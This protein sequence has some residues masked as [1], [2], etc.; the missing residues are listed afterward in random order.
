M[1]IKIEL[2]DSYFLSKF[3]VDDITEDYIDWL[4]DPKIVNFLEV[5]FL[6]QDRETVTSYINSF[7]KDFEKYL[8]GVYSKDSSSLVGTIN[9]YNI[10]R[11]HDSAEISIM[12][13][14]DL[15]WGK[16]ASYSAMCWV[17][18][19]AFNEL[20]L[21]KIY[22]GTYINNLGMNFTLKRLGLSIEAKLREAYYIKKNEY[23]DGLRWGLLKK[24][25]K[26]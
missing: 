26:N 25:W 9:L 22:G 14:N 8:W 19:Y 6:K 17:I 16:G 24:E 11:Y 13:G 3:T 4:N 23:A 18:N 10:N 2:N 20:N 7:Y 5:R 15:H 21:R 12:I 1:A